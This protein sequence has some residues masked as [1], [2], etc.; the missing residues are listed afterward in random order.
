MKLN[1]DFRLWLT[2]MPSKAFP[3][4]V[5]Q[6]GIKITNEPPKGLRANIKRTYEDMSEKYYHIIVEASTVAKDV[7]WAGIFSCS[8]S[9]TQKIWPAWLEYIIRVECQ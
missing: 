5:L 1:A 7:I 9:G 8:L 2:S 6:N 4:S 3:V